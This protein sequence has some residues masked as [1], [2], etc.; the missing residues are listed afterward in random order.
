MGKRV[1]VHNLDPVPEIYRFL[2]GAD[3]ITSGPVLAGR[4]DAVV[5]LDAEPSRTGLFDAAV[6]AEVLINVDHHV[7]NPRVWPLTWLDADAAATGEL[8]H[9]LIRN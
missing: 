5:V 1:A 8:V 9:A 4:Y 7:T 6:P 2:P 3:R